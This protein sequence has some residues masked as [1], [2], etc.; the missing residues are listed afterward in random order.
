MQ[1]VRELV[2]EIECAAGNSLGEDNG[3]VD[4]IFVSHSLGD[5]FHCGTLEQIDPSVPLISV[6][7]VVDEVKK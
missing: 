5:H 1:H 3:E 7:S 2:L 6:Q 4:T